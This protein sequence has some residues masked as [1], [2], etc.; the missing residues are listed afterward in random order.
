[1]SALVGDGLNVGSSDVQKLVRQIR[2]RTGDREL[3][4]DLRYVLVSGMATR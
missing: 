3:L 4:A 1:M 2:Q